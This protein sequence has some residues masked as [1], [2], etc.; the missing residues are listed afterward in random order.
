LDSAL[1]IDGHDEIALYLAPVGKIWMCY[2]KLIYD[3]M[4]KIIREIV[5][6]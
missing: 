1:G 4:R 2:W 3:A 6:D 5:L